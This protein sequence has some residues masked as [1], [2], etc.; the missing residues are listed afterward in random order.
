MD[1]FS[2]IVGGVALSQVCGSTAKELH[3]LRCSYKKFDSEMESLAKVIDSLAS[4][5]ETVSNVCKEN[6]H[7]NLRLPEDKQRIRK[8]CGDLE[9]NFDDSSDYI[10]DLRTLLDEIK[11]EPDSEGKIS[12]KFGKLK[13]VLRR[14][15]REDEMNDIRGRI[16]ECYTAIDI[17]LTA[18]N[19]FYVQAL[20]ESTKTTIGEAKLELSEL[21][22]DLI[23]QLKIDL[24]AKVSQNQE[25]IRELLSRR[26]STVAI[27]ATSEQAGDVNRHYH[28]PQSVVTYFTGREHLLEELKRAFDPRSPDDGIQPRQFVVQGLPGSGKTQFCC[29]FASLVRELFWA[30]FWIDASSRE[31]ADSTFCV[32]AA[33]GKVAPNM[34]AAKDW[35]ANSKAP[36]LLLID[37]A[38][39]TDIPIEEYFPPNPRGCILITTRNP[40]H[41]VHGNVGRNYFVFNELEHKDAEN[42]LLRAAHVKK[43][44]A[45]EILE[46][47]K[48]ISEHMCYVSYSFHSNPAPARS[49]SPHRDLA[50][51]CREK[52]LGRGHFFALNLSDL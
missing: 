45:N 28:T 4:V 37:N 49:K 24:L 19:L 27:Y 40:A 5:T 11:G 38:D 7:R 16:Q 32:I 42:L 15:R 36:W 41:Q 33:K 6:Q 20:D 12:A 31:S 22:S 1:P 13:K 50:Q 51:P 46:A 3:D 26:A 10:K 29:Q 30:V 34:K 39:D 52:G 47:A 2:L 9:R 14:E 43:P 17:S 8:L 35:L 23:S 25:E 18:L 48:H 44:C 21:Y